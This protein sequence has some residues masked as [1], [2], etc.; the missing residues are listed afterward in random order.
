MAIT[1][2][3]DPNLEI[4][5]YPG[6]I[7][8]IFTNLIL[9][10]LVHG[11]TEQEKG[12]ISIQ[13]ELNDRFFEIIYSDGGKG[14]ESGNLKKIFEPFFTTN[15]KAGTGLGLHIVHNLITQKL[16]GSITVKS[17]QGEGVEFRISIP[18]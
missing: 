9:N 10:S 4:K 2:D 11:Y 16:N 17:N 3:I 15:K 1:L 8:Q 14:V 6:I 18:L 12:Q 7:S 13:S 5:S